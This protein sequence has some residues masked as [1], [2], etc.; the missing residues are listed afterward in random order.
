MKL[1][2]L[3]VAAALSSG[4]SS[5]GCTADPGRPD[6]RAATRPPPPPSHAPVGDPVATVAQCLL[7]FESQIDWPDASTTLVGGREGW[8]TAV[9][10]C[11][12]PQELAA[13][14]V[15]L[16]QAIGPAGLSADWPAR[17]EGWVQGLV[18]PTPA[19]LAQAVRRLAEAVREG[20]LSPGWSGKRATLLERLDAVR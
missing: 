16:E 18:S 1:Q 19:T 9:R 15:Q 12:T 13:A 8:S 5:R 10:Q 2:S 6:A 17:R 14:V 4:C 11:R 20:R 7:D 3:L